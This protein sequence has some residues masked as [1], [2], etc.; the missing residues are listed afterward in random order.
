[1]AAFGSPVLEVMHVG[2]GFFIC[3]GQFLNNVYN[4]IVKL[5]GVGINYCYYDSIIIK[6]KINNH[7]IT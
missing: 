2:M 6:R 4:L 3:N 5:F 1:M 7:Q